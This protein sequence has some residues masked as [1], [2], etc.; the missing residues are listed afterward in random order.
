MELELELELLNVTSSPGAEYRG[1]MLNVETGDKLTCTY[2]NNVSVQPLSDV[3]VNNTGKS[4]EALVRCT[5]CCAEPVSELLIV[6][7]QLTMDPLEIWLES[8]NI[9]VLPVHA[10]EL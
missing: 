1:D 4:P 3:V 5:A 7:F 2:F 6:Q 10:S 8:V 9:M